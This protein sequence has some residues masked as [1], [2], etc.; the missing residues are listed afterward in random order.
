MCISINYQ[1]IITLFQ[2]D[3][4]L[5]RSP[6]V[7]AKFNTCNILTITRNITLTYYIY[8]IHIATYLLY[9]TAQHM[10]NKVNMSSIPMCQLKDTMIG[11]LIAYT[12]ILLAGRLSGI[13]GRSESAI[14]SR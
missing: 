8:V 9:S 12:A 14:G 1:R 4:T 5:N 2:H 11:Y 7:R 3:I 13:Q 10:Y 6:F